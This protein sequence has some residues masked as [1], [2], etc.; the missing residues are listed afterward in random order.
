MPGTPQP[1]PKDAAGDTGGPEGWRSPNN[2][3]SVLKARQVPKDASVPAAGSKDLM[4][5]EQFLEVVF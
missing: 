1:A 4:L 2:L 5:L 3:V